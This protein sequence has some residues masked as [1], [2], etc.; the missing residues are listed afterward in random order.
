MP[1]SD[2]EEEMR[3]DN[4]LDGIFREREQFVIS[5]IVKEHGNTAEVV[6]ILAE[7]T[8][9][10]QGV[11]ADACQLYTSVTPH[12]RVHAYVQGSDAGTTERMCH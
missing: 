8:N 9:G 2:S 7:K 10:T 6:E 3:G 4:T 5:S 11:Q 1:A 12:Q